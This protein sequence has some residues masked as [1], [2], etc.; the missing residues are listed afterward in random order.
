M[1]SSHFFT[2]HVLQPTRLRSKTLID[3]IFLNSLEYSA[4]SGNL[5]YELSDHLIQF[6][7]LEGFS[8]ERSLPEN[9]LYKR[10]YSNYSDAE[11]EETVINGVNWDEICML[12]LKNPSVSVKNFHDTIHFH[13]DEMAPLKNVTLKQYRLMIKPWITKDILKKCDER[14]NLLKLIKQESDPDKIISL[15]KDYKTLRN[16]IS[17]EKRNSKKAHFTKRFLEIKDNSSKIWK[18][19]RSLVN[20]KPTKTPTIKILD[21]NQNILSDSQKIA[22]IFNDHYATLGSK[23]QQKI[24]TQ[25]G[26]FNFYLDKRD[27][28]G[29]RLAR[30]HL[31]RHTTL[32]IPSFSYFSSCFGYKGVTS[33]PFPLVPTHSIF[34][35]TSL[36]GI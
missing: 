21:E 20:I 11:F 2:P 22:N 8:K 3:N 9:N 13:L 14:N 10:D 19:I 33:I 35:L 23:V 12:R 18:E 4:N 31:Y 34:P 24:P 36:V 17:Q 16:K 28:N 32:P 15:R 25:E 30:L 26:D 27:K 6:L 5:L 29:R 1:F 7:I